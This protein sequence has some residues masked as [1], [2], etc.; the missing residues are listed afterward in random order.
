MLQSGATVD[1]VRPS[2]AYLRERVARV[3]DPYGLALTL[4]VLAHAP[5]HESEAHELARRLLRLG[6]QN[7]WKPTG[8][9]LV[10]SS[11]DAAAVEVTALVVLGLSKLGIEPVALNDAVARLHALK[12]PTGMWYTTTGTVLALKA[13]LAERSSPAPFEGTLAVSVDGKPAGEV[14]VSGTNADIMKILDLKAATHTG[15]HRVRIEPRLSRP[16]AFAVQLTSSYYL[17]WTGLPAAAP[18]PLVVKQTFDRT[19]L[20][21]DDHLV[22]KVELDYTAPASGSMMLLDLGVPPGFAIETADLDELVEKAV[23]S[24]YELTGRQ[25]ILYVPPLQ[26][27]RTVRFSYRLRA[28]FP[29]RAQTP[30]STVYEYYD[31]TSRVALPPVALEVN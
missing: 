27:D 6:A 29:M 28:R 12:Q 1:D 24:R 4:N 22:A 5:G 2:L 16:H 14:P 19:T 7:G 10:C 3:E 31:P 23:I 13:L 20:A 21:V 25:A 15:P 8:R 9:T 11:G 26:R 30:P 18:P 17:P